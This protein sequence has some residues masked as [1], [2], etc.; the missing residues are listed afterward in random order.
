MQMGAIVLK[1]GSIVFVDEFIVTKAVSRQL[2][3]ELTTQ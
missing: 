2:I 3:D 1:V